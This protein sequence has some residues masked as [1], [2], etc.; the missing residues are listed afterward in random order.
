MKVFIASAANLEID[1]KYLELARNV[2]EVFAKNNYDLL[3]G[4]GYYSMMGECYNI[5]KKYKRKI[6]A[7]TVS[8]WESDFKKIP[9]AKRV[10]TSDT[11]MRFRKLYFDCDVMVILPGGIG[12]IA[13]F[14]SALEES[15]VSGKSKRIIL[16]NFEGYYDELISFMKNNI[17][18]GFFKDDL[19]DSYNIIDNIEELESQIL[20]YKEHVSI[21]R[22]FK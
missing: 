19:S 18:T 2:S 10:K 7:Y 14:T 1:D 17:E 13:E 20:K 9:Y 5:F 22:K 3:F 21:V 15:R 6:Y 12:T 4:A 8:R 11:L 16:Y